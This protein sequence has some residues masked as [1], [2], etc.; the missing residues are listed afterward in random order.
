M[1]QVSTFL[2]CSQGQY[3]DVNICRTLF[4]TDSVL[5]LT[6][7]SSILC[8]FPDH[9][10]PEV[11]SL[12]LFL[13]FAFLAASA[14]AL[15]QRLLFPYYVAVSQCHSTSHFWLVVVEDADFRFCCCLKPQPPGNGVC[16]V[17]KVVPSTG[18]PGCCWSPDR[19]QTLS[20]H[21]NFSFSQVSKG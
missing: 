2:T 4:S 8:L 20:P 1:N 5:C 10:K 17:G 11:S 15:S 3:S 9:L 13:C 18:S 14:S 6:S 12:T 16:R 21:M 19:H 7:I